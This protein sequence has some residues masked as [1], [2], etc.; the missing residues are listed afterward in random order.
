MDLTRAAI[1]KNR[2]TAVVLAFVL[3]G[4]WSA[5]RTLPRAEDPGFI[6]RTAQVMTFFPGASPERVEQ[7]VTDRL[8]KAILEIPEVESIDSISKTGVSVLIV[9]V[10]ERHRVMRP[11]W[12][13]LRRKIDREAPNLPDG[14]Q[15][16]VVNDEFGDVFGIVLALTGDG[17]S[18]A[19]LKDIADEMRSELLRLPDVAKVEIFGTQDQR[20]FVE[21][22]GARLAE[23]G[24]TPA[25]LAAVLQSQNIVTSGG[26]VRL[27]RE[28]IVIEPSG[29]FESLGEIERTLVRIPA[30]GEILY[31]R[32]LVRVERGYVDP[33][34]DKV[35]TGTGARFFHGR[36]LVFPG[37]K[38]NTA[39]LVLAV[40]MSEGGLLT[41]LGAQVVEQV[42][43]F[44]ANY[45]H[46]IQIDPVIFQ[47]ED[48]QEVIDG[49]T[50]SLMQAVGV[51]MLSMLVFL[52]LRTGLVVA[53]L[54]PTAMM[55]TLLVMQVLG[56]G[57]DQISLA[58]LIIALGMLVDNGVVMAESILVQMSNGRPGKEAAIDSARELRIPL[59]TS[60]LT[61][62]AAFLPIY[63][64]ESATGEYTAALFEVVTI[65][66]L[67][68]WLLSLTMTPTLCATFLRVAPNGSGGSTETFTS[69][70]YRR[71]RAVLVTL[72]RRP[73]VTMLGVALVFVGAMS[74]ASRV[75]SL[76]FPTSDRPTFEIEIEMPAGTAIEYTRKAVQRLEGFMIREL[77]VG[78]E[79]PE[80]V[81]NWASFIGKG[82][83][84]YYL[85]YGP[86]PPDPSY[87]IMLVRATSREA[88]DP[89]MARL[90][91]HLRELAP[92]ANARVSPRRL[93][94][95][96]SHPVQV[97]LIGSEPETLFGIVDEVKA[98]LRE[99]PIARNVG[100]DW[101]MRTKKLIVDVD[102][103]RA[104]AAQI[105]SEDVAVSLQ[106]LFSGITL[107][108]YRE[109]DEVIP[110]TMRSVEEE[111]LDLARLATV[112]IYSPAAGETVQ[113][114]Q[115][116]DVRI[117][118]E[119][120]KILRRNADRAVSV[121]ADVAEGALVAD[122]NAE[123][124]P[125]LE[126]RSQTWPIGY[127]FEIAGEDET[128]R[129][130]NASIGE[131]LP[132]AAGIIALLLVTQ[133][134][135]IRRP[136]I[137]LLTV[138]LGL[139]GVVVGLLLAD[140][141]FGFM[142]LLGVI[143]LF[144]IVINNAIVLIDRI[145][146]EIERGLPPPQAIVEAAQTRLRPIL[147]TTATTILG[148]LPLWWGGGPMWEPMAIAIIFGLA[149]ATLL[150]LGV[151]PVL[152]ALL[153]G[154]RI[155]DS[156]PDAGA[157]AA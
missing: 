96:V 34:E 87:A 133:F 29:N 1:E 74:A 2:I 23:L 41:E 59:L 64:A 75:P 95:P 5:F 48:V 114:S 156:S 31:L 70:V 26:S 65:A 19:Q 10:E 105:T 61:T 47:P 55:A 136:L 121:V 7:L 110:V 116:A 33:P 18:Y 49:F 143:S 50:S 68:S 85:S 109:G 37:E 150:T 111:R 115:I 152:Y 27:D 81:V 60:S 77:Q 119:P 117:V 134:N 15:P 82:A 57:L 132:I 137:I 63:L 16:P 54:I 112:G 4:G 36:P 14:V 12:D 69:P 86:E 149:F 157:S 103:S 22:D 71:Y 97:R 28:R 83:P 126:E 155:V 153:F 151:V 104:R 123:L 40:S 131:K 135:S 42:R 3:L 13:T 76:F 78:D 145:G 128:S 67:A 91:E 62:S 144:G 88:M 113:L 101:G 9:N 35:H 102:Q 120:S 30:T 94:P 140:S 11:I 90:R 129:K 17:F 73:G 106:T 124:L 21:Y 45:P 138:P 6:I 43:R 39:A 56:I 20:V 99:I 24:M 154:A 84:R 139:I 72:L 98:R 89:V 8:E 125:W 122:V 46:G 44:N 66:L 51:V 127:R 53:T 130:A 148:L 142:T 25:Q 32:D 92:E 108:Q 52:G 100:D 93:G 80:G 147:L 58:A 107:T 38:P 141:Y 79:R 118:W 146:I